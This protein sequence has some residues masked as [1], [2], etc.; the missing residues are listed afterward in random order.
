MRMELR[1]SN[2][3][4][5]SRVEIDERARPAR[6]QIPL[7]GGGAAAAGGGGG[8]G[9]GDGATQDLFL[10]WDG[11]LD[12]AMALRKCVVC[13]CSDLYTRKNLPQVTPFIVVLALSGATVALLGYATNPVVVAL[14]AALL[15]V[16][17][18][19]LLLARRQLVCYGCGAVYWSLRIARY[20]RPWDRSVAERLG[21]EPIELPTVLL[22]PE[23]RN[24]P[25]AD[26]PP[27]A[28]PE[29]RQD[30][31]QEPRQQPNQESSQGSNQS[32]NQGL[33]QGSNQE[34]RR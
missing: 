4:R 24:D 9:T 7:P 22:E 14:L 3:R 8:P 12:D 25:R 20:H 21:G 11:A 18:L 15:V 16:D 34:S 2:G 26:G 28:R 30:A 17:V 5:L 10:R 27:G 32:S 23:R 1:D 29:S 13:S 33:N 19:T 6:V 31:K